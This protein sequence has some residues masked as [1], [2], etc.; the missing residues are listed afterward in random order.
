MTSSY[1][2]IIVGSGITGLY[3]APIAIIPAFRTV[4]VK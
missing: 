2:Y 4:E 1:D 3:A